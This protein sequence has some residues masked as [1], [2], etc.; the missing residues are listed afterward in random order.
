MR[1]DQLMFKII[2]LFESKLWYALYF[3]FD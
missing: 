3:R 2:V 1:F